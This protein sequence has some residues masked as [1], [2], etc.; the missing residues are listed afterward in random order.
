[1]WE[2]WAEYFEQLYQV[3]PPTVNL[4]SGN[5]IIQLPDPPISEDALLLTEVRGVISKLNS[6]KAAGI[7]DIPAVNLWCLG[8]MLSRGH[9]SLEG[10][11]G[12][13]GLHHQGIT[14]LSI[15]GKVLAHILLRRIR[16]HLLWHQRPEQSGFTPGKS[17]IDCIL[18]LRVTVE[19]HHEFGRELLTAYIELKKASDMV[20]WES[21]WEILRQKNSNKDYWTNSKSVY[22]YCKCS[23]IWW[24]PVELL[25]C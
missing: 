10:E 4:D 1:M 14:K 8:C 22:W 23:K 11:G 24:G 7:C 17:T 3:D 12:L 6:G 2:R 20:H 21:L 18:A 25:S 15:P 9:P 13:M 19:R 5:A 16:D